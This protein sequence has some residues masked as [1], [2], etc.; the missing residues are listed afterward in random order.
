M[1]IVDRPALLK[2]RADECEDFGSLLRFRAET[3]PDR[4][5]FVFLADGENEAATIT[6]GSCIPRDSNSS[7]RSSGACMRES[8]PFQ[9]I[10]PAGEVRRA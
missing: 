8:S 3:E 6:Y 5:A 1:S 2:R 7:V 4:K 9:F 10:H